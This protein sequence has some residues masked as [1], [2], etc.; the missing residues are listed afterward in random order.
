MFHGLR[1]S[2]GSH[3]FTR[4]SSRSTVSVP[5]PCALV[6]AYFQTTVPTPHR[7]PLPPLKTV[8]PC[9]NFGF[10]NS[11][12]PDH[13]HTY[14]HLCCLSW[15][16]PWFGLIPF[17]VSF[18]SLFTACHHSSH[19]LRDRIFRRQLN[20]FLSSLPFAIKSTLVHHK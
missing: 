9:C 12:F 5:P 11:S 14:R 8:G 15:N 2:I 17:P 16:V 3:R 1:R 19:S 18:V 6:H 10:E 13:A 7:T 4:P 20:I